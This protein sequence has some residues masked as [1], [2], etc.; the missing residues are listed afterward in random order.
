MW[1]VAKNKF[2]DHIVYFDFRTTR[3]PH[4]Q[5][6]VLQG[7][8]QDK[9]QGKTFRQ[10]LIDI[11]PPKDHLYPIPPL[12]DDAAPLTEEAYFRAW[13]L[14]ALERV[15]APPGAGVAASAALFSLW[16]LPGGGASEVLFFAALGTWLA[17]L[18]RA[19]GGSRLLAAG[20]HAS[21]NLIVVLLRASQ[22]EG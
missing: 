22:F 7:L 15:G 13:L 10:K 16:H 3:Y 21:F 20:T 12:E 19:S 6:K 11:D 8:K 1:G 4:L 5:K 18:F 9:L 2:S 14:P 17:V